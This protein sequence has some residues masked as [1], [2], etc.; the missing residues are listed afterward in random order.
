MYADVFNFLSC[1]PSELGSSDVSDYKTSK[2][3]SCFNRG[4]LGPLPFHN[5]SQDCLYCFLKANCRPSERLN[6]PPHKLWICV[7]KKDAVIKASYCS[8][9]AGMSE[10]CNHVAAALFRVEAAVRLGLTNP[11]VQ[12]NRVNGYLIVKKSNRLKLNI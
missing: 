9:M 6:D 12:Q 4:W 11:Y 10:T 7:S 5:I 1:H 8:C 3:Y 2:A